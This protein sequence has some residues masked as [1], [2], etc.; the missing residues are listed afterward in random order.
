MKTTFVVAMLVLVVTFAYGDDV[1][2]LRAGGQAAVDELHRQLGVATDR[3]KAEALLDRVC[4]QKD[5]RVSRLF[6]YTDLEEARAA[7]RRVRRPILALHLLGR[8]DE[9]MSCA[10]S[11]FFRT[12]LYSDES[13][14][15]ILR[16][17]YV[18]Y[19]HSVRPVPRVTI[20]LGDGRVI[21]Q[22]ITGNSAHY[23]L[24]E[25]GEVLDALP[26]LHSPSAFRE[27]LERWL[28]LYRSFDGNHDVL[29][30]Y[31]E[32]RADVLG[33]RAFQLGVVS[34]DLE[35]PVARLTAEQ[36]AVLATTKSLV[37]TPMLRQLDAGAALRIEPKLRWLEIG[38]EQM[39]DVDFS[40]ASIALIRQK[41][42]GNR[43]PQRG[44]LESLLDNLRRTVATDTA[45]NELDLHLRIH[46]WFANDEVRDLEAL[47]ERIYR[48]LFLTPS[49][50]P[51]MGLKEPGVF[52][53][54]AE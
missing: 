51:W 33:A 38:E 40:A 16:D 39:N 9:E 49:D 6:W 54:L 31:H 8:L 53:A 3:A 2:E 37:E 44:E 7:A 47:N 5:C 13:I 42:F 10:N 15:G 43:V 45:F 26:G 36:A 48:E 21:R 32:D 34:I 20:D 41:Q 4:G 11:R 24:A 28:E 17:E 30:R 18:L 19:W 14:A 35:P 23:L 46:G 27:Q 25:N 29:R 12:L 1:A 22:T 52:T 50:D